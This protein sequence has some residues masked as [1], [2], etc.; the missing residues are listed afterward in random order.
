GPATGPRRWR[1]AVIAVCLLAGLLLGT[2]RAYS[3]GHEIR[4]RSSDLSALVS[5]AEQR[6]QT[7]RQSAASLQ[8]RVDAEAGRDVSPQV[9]R[10]RAAAA[11]LRAPAGLTAVHGPGVRVTLTDA[12]RDASGQYPAGVNPDDLVVHQQDVQSVVNALW[13]GGGE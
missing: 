12:P 10:A 6:V 13:A 5:G 7:L 8:E 1:A 3:G 2:A 4:G 9:A 11:G